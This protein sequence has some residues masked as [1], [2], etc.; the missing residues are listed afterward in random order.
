MGRVSTGAAASLCLV[1]PMSPGNDAV[2]TPSPGP[3]GLAAPPALLTPSPAPLPRSPP[4]GTPQPALSSGAV[5]TR[6]CAFS[7]QASVGQ[8]PGDS[9]RLAEERDAGW[10]GP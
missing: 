7:V 8:R 5:R 6:T 4:T 1:Q 3:P 10:K 2:P 9:P